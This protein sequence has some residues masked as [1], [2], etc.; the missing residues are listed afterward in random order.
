M[1]A[2][3]TTPST[4]GFT[5]NAMIACAAISPLTI[6][7]TLLLAP[8]VTTAEGEP[9][10]RALVANLDAYAL[11]SW[12]GALGTVTLIPAIFAVSKVA[13]SGRPVLGLVGMIL[14]FAMALPYGLTSDDTIYAAAKAG[15]DVPTTNRLV[16]QLSEG[17]PTSILGFTFFLSLLGFVLLGVAALR[18]AAPK[19]AAIAMIVAPVLIPVPWFA[20]LPA[21]AGGVAWLV[22]TAATTGIALA[23]LS[24]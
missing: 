23:L 14:A 19:W 6:A 11:W 3:E 2:V 24:R 15:L 10:I 18:G 9:Y 8:F 20:G 7:A 1:T 22:F 13:R 5:R 21:A 4:T 16:T 12:V 17:T